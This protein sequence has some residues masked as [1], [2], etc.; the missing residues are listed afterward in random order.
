MLTPM[1]PLG[2][3]GFALFARMDFT[4]AM[5]VFN[6]WA[7]SVHALHAVLPAFVLDATPDTTSQLVLVLVKLV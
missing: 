6:A 4:P 5:R 1:I 3:P 7:V 2:P